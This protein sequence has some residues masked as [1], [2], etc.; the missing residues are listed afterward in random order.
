MEP[1]I[2][3]P[4]KLH[5]L[6]LGHCLPCLFMSIVSFCC[7]IAALGS[8]SEGKN[9]LRKNSLPLLSE[10]TK[11][12]KVCHAGGLRHA[13]PIAMAPALTFPSPAR[14]LC[15]P[16][17]SAPFFCQLEWLSEGSFNLSEMSSSDSLGMPASLSLDRLFHTQTD[18]SNLS[19]CC[20]P[21]TES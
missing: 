7:L 16:T 5:W 11:E 20:S 12:R 15:A 10:F 2:S 14:T 18:G 19:A 21:L 4:I 1:S 9:W 17:F 6:S 8:Y 13:Q 3:P